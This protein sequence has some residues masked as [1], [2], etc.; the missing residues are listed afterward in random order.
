MLSASRADLE[1]I[2]DEIVELIKI[3][4]KNSSAP[5]PDDD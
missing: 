5:K 3:E 4:S 2:A 1:A